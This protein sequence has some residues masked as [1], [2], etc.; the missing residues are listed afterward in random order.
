MTSFNP[1]KDFGHSTFIL[2]FFTESSI[3]QLCN[4]TLFLAFILKIFLSTYVCTLFRILHRIQNFGIFLFIKFSP[5]LRILYEP[6]SPLKHGPRYSPSKVNWLNLQAHL[7]QKSQVCAACSLFFR[8]PKLKA[9]KFNE[10]TPM[11]ACKNRTIYDEIFFH[12]IYTPTPFKLEYFKGKS[13]AQWNR[14]DS[15]FSRILEIQ[16]V[17]EI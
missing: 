2:Q 11:A 10:V 4:F 8:I 1:L 17:L 15:E 6:P 7:S 12:G 16:V 9:L 3:V 14:F 13:L 5:L